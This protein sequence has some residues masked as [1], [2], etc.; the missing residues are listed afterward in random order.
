[1]SKPQQSLNPEDKNFAEICGW[2]PSDLLLSSYWPIL[3]SL[4]KKTSSVTSLIGKRSENQDYGIAFQR[5]DNESSCVIMAVADGLGG[6][7]GGKVAAY[8]ACKGVV[9]AASV[10][11]T[12]DLN[13]L[14]AELRTGA[15]RS[16]ASVAEHTP[17]STCLTTVIIAVVTDKCYLVTWLGDGGAYIRR[18]NAVWQS[19]MEP[20][21]G[22]SG[23]EFEVGACLGAVQKGT[24]LT[25]ESVWCRGDLFMIG[26]DGVTERTAAARETFFKR[27]L[28]R[29]AEGV[30]LQK[31]MTDWLT[32]CA[33]NYP[34]HFDDNMTLAALMTP[35]NIK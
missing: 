11:I 18:S 28:L 4:S 33:T 19:V 14:L 23:Y 35:D 22:P 32:I 30:D 3:Q 5:K 25:S 2:T 9:D 6:H 8:L 29:V 20:H 15:A 24:W 26:T 10:I 21:R 16:L 7:P 27:P 17:P 13:H 12:S 31:A 1:M 34:D